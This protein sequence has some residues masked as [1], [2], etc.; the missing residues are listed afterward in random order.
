MSQW[1]V[2]YRIE[3]ADECSFGVAEFFRGT[4]REC[5][6]IGSA[7]ACGSCDIVRTLPW[8]VVVGPAEDWDRFLQEMSEE[9]L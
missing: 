5:K 6:R 8:Q 4:E 3:R 7:F 9:E 2:T 1:V